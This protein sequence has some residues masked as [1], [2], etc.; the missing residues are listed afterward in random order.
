VRRAAIIVAM[1][2]TVSGDGELDV[3]ISFTGLGE[4]CSLF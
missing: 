1:N 2:R 3:M 4:D